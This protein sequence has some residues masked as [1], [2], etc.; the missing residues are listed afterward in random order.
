M[1]G[2]ALTLAALGCRS[3][4][5]ARGAVEIRNLAEYATVPY[6]FRGD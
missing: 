3:S 5:Q 6:R 2:M 4:F 1:A